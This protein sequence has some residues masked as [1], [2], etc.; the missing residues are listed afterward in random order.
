MNE[1]TLKYYKNIFIGKT[2]EE[3]TIKE[4]IGHGKSAIVFK[5][6]KK[7]TIIAIKIFL[8]E[9]VNKYGYEMQTDRI[10]RE[11]G[12]INHSIKNLVQILGGGSITLNDI[13]YLYIL[14]NYIDG[15]TLDEIIQ[16]RTNED[17]GFALKVFNILYQVTEELIDLKLAH[18]D[19]KPPNIMVL[20]DNEIIIMDLGVVKNIG[21]SS[22]TDDEDG[23]E[24]VGTLRYSPPEFLLGIE[25]DN[26]DGWRA[27]NI[28]QI[29]AVIHDIIM[30]IPLFQQYSKPY[31]KLV[32][33]V[34]TKNVNINNPKYSIPVCKY[35]SNLLIKNWEK[36]LIF[37]NSSDYKKIFS[38]NKSNLDSDVFNSIRKET[39]SIKDELFNIAQE[40]SKR[41]NKQKELDIIAENIKK[42]SEEVIQSFQS[43]SLITKYELFSDNYDRRINE[44]CLIFELHGDLEK[45]FLDSGKTFILLIIKIEESDIVYIGCRGLVIS[46][47]DFPINSRKNKRIRASKLSS[48]FTKTKKTIIINGGQYNTDIFKTEFKNVVGKIITRAINVMK[49]YVKKEIAYQKACLDGTAP[50]MRTISEHY[51]KL[52]DTIDD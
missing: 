20:Q 18:R 3:Y 12:L 28:Y 26:I 45:G 36:R 7:E 49:P 38:S 40:H 11:Q 50:S 27:I 44:R 13:Q 34:L 30:G 15:E 35:I 32:E 21:D 22:L 2:I 25:Q 16:K 6:K 19:I 4:Y 42:D 33:A 51:C 10:K 43:E 47:M 31:G 29:G 41:R 9:I 5:A 14:M 23:K 52:I 48:E 46:E 1:A 37:F 8:E 39:K 24:F 17:D